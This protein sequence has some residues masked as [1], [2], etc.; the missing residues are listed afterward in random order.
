M[1][2]VKPCPCLIAGKRA[3]AR[4]DR[5]GNIWNPST[6]EVIAQTPFCGPEDV[7]RADEH[8]ERVLRAL[9]ALQRRRPAP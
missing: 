7:D 3:E 8:R 6:G 4:T 5:F 1:P 9:V 2:D